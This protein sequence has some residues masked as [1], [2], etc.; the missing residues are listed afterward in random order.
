MR[1]AERLAIYEEFFHTINVHCTTMNQEKIR[2]AVS[3]ID[4]WS[5]AHRAGNGEPS[6]YEQKKMVEQVIE[7]M[8]R[9][10]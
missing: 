5:Y 9:F 8:S 1:K 4:A 7:R 10:H 6:D 3:L 2:E